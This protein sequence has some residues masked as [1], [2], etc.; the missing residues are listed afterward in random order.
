MTLFQ[1]AT[2]LEVYGALMKSN[3]NGGSVAL[4]AMRDA[5]VALAERTAASLSGNL[6]LG[7]DV[8]KLLHASAA[9]VMP[10]SVA[11]ATD[12]GSSEKGDRVIRA[13]QQIS[14]AVIVN[15]VPGQKAETVSTPEVNS[16]VECILF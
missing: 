3:A 9:L 15:L 16:L 10:A 8:V 6:P 13:L 5:S 2:A 4:S 14:Q 1:V 7:L 12:R 11:S